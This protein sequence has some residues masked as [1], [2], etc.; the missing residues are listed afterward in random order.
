MQETIPGPNFVYFANTI[1]AAYTQGNALGFCSN[2]EEHTTY[3]L[4]QSILPS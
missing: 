1:C 3:I 2:A 4:R